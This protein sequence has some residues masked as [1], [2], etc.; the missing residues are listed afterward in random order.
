MIGALL[1]SSTGPALEEAAVTSLVEASAQIR[2]AGAAG[3]TPASG[4][5]A[6]DL[7]KAGLKWVSSGS[8]AT[9]PFFT[10]SRHIYETADGTPVVLLIAFSPDFRP[11]PQWVAHRVGPY[12]LLTWTRFGRRYVLGGATMTRGMM[13]AAD[14]IGGA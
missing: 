1:T 5:A 3:G 6:P 7:S 11:R 14:M 2:H 10:A 8:V 12:R 13:E 4:P 9:G